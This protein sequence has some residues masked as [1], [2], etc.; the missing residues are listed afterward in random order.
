MSPGESRT[1]RDEPSLSP[2]GLGIRHGEPDLQP[3]ESAEDVTELVRTSATW[4]DARRSLNPTAVSL[5][6][7]VSRRVLDKAWNELKRVASV[8][9][10]PPA[11]VDTA[12]HASERVRGGAPRDDDTATLAARANLAS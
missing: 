1:E 7:G 9:E 11:R 12:P 5:L 2:S 4:A 8:R 10:D 6:F 3:A